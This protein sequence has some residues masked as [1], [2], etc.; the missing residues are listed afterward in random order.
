MFLA[1]HVFETISKD[2]PQ[3]FVK[4]LKDSLAPVQSINIPTTESSYLGTVYVHSHKNN[5]TVSAFVMDHRG[6]CQNVFGDCPQRAEIF[7]TV[8]ELFNAIQNGFKDIE[9]DIKVYDFGRLIITTEFKKYDT[10]TALVLRLIDL[11]KGEVTS[12]E[13]KV[14]AVLSKVV[15]NV[16]K[17]YYTDSSEMTQL[18]FLS[19][20]NGSVFT[21]TRAGVGPGDLAVRET[22]TIFTNHME[23]RRFLYELDLKITCV[24]FNSIGV[25]L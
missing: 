15:L 13:I 17:A 3:Q 6:K 10:S 25:D 24:V 2:E 19:F 9:L 16:I 12:D 4:T 11:T 7:H 22:R 20:Q 18:S 8:F 1:K 23:L 5:K 14:D 21:P